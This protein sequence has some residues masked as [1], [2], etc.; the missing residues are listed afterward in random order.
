MLKSVKI[1][2]ENYTWLARLAGELQKQRGVPVSLDDALTSL[3]RR[4]SITDLAGSGEMTDREYA[5]FLKKVRE[6]W[7]TWKPASA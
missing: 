4:G 5:A 3:Q 2:K 7:N 6:G 1:R